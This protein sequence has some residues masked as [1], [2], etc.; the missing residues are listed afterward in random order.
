MSLLNTLLVA[1]SGLKVASAGVSTTSH[2]VA[3]A[4][5]EGYHVRST[6]TETADPVRRGAAWFGQGTTLT[7]IYRA[8]DAFLGRRQLE[9]AGDEAA[10]S[11]LKDSLVQVE[12]W[13][14]E[15]R[16]D[17]LRERLDQYYDALTEATADP[18]DRGLRIGVS[19]AAERL[20]EVLRR[21]A[22][23]LDQQLSDFEDA[24]EGS[25]QGINEKLEEI[26]ALNKGLAAAGGALS[27]G[28]L[29]DRRDALIRD[30]SVAVGATAHL[31][32]EGRATVLIGGHAVVSGI[33]A[34]SIRV[35]VSGPTP[36]VFMSADSGEVD[37]TAGGT[38]GGRMEAHALTAGYRARLDTFA[39]DFA[40]TTNTQHQAGFD[41][42][43]VA[44]TAIFTFDPS[45]PAGSF[46]P[47]ASI[48]ADPDLIAFASGATGAAGDAGN[49]GLLMGLRETG[50][51]GATLDTPEDFLSDLTSD[52]GRDT[53]TADVAASANAAILADLD[54]LDQNLHGVDL[55]EQAQNLITYQTAY[56]AAAKV[57]AS[58]QT[59][60]D[61]LMSIA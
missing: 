4:A 37:I 28:D 54:E 49:L 26:A 47:A 29:A 43:G 21:T 7:G 38:L 12:T 60:L 50:S 61:A 48:L 3:N 14:D 36:Q 11:S 22:N 18:S 56:Q 51:I 10:S 17:G 57:L 13:F 58:T 59:M 32:G 53:N 39:T 16:A 30:L 34:R 6:T 52:V 44:G 31:D 19:T 27:A 24:L 23:G 15:S 2:N 40:T 41:A 25:T 9:A 5:T 42:S 33:E 20:G 1:G 35:D 46:T 8:A 55:D 45:D